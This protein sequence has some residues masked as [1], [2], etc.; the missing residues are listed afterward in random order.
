MGDGTKETWSSCR[1]IESLAGWERRD[2]E[3]GLKTGWVSV[4]FSGETEAGKGR[5]IQA[6]YL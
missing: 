3:D 6:E 2:E 4:G 1:D 5:E